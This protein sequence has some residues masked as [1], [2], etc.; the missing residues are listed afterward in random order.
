M[1][2]TTLLPLLST[3]LQTFYF[4]VTKC[5][6]ED[7]IVFIDTLILKNTEDFPLKNLNDYYL[8]GKRNNIPIIVDKEQYNYYEQSK[9]NSSSSI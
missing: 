3:D 9:S 2:P 7:Q 5:F 1:T 4:L 8:I 6:V